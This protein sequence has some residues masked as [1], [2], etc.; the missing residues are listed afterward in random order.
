MSVQL[1]GGRTAEELVEFILAANQDG[2]Q[3]EALIAELGSEFGLS[4][5][6]AE[7]S[8]DRVGGGI[9]RAA[10]GSGSNNRQTIGLAGPSACR[11]SQTGNSKDHA[12]LM[13]PF[14]RVFT[15]FAGFPTR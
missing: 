12:I 13:P 15:T 4:N 3:H 10:T 2:R 14:G 6:D 8:V 11:R 1:P 5:E 7:L 9:V